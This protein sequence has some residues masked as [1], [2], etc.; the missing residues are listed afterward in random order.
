MNREKNYEFEMRHY[1]Y[2]SNPENFLRIRK[3]PP[4]PFYPGI[5]K[6]YLKKG[7]II[8]E[9]FHPVFSRE[10]N[11]HTKVYW[12]VKGDIYSK[13]I[14]EIVRSIA[15]YI[16]NISIEYLSLKESNE[17]KLINELEWKEGELKFKDF[18]KNEEKVLPKESKEYLLFKNALVKNN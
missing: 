1:Y 2:N 8:G 14:S 10:K 17:N 15:D 6:S 13:D 12:E 18:L 9:V 3:H 5:I 4:Q 11:E 16:P 7:K